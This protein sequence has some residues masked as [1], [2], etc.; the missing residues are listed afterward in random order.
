MGIFIEADRFFPSSQICSI[1]GNRKH[2]LKLSDRTYK[3]EHCGN[4]MNRDL[5]AAR[6]LATYRQFDGKLSPWRTKQTKVA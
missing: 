6:N 4:E 3:C 1:C 2:D 5:N